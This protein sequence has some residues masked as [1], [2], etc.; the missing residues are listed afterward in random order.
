MSYI[1]K[2]SSPVGPVESWPIVE[3]D[4]EKWYVAPVYVAP[5]ARRDIS[6]VCD[7]WGCEVPTAKLVDA[8][9]EQSDLKLDCTK[10]RRNYNSFNDM[11]TNTAYELQSEKIL[12]QISEQLKE[13]G[14]D[15]YSI[16]SGT[17]KDFAILPNG[18][19]DLYGWHHL[20]GTLT[21]KGATSHSQ[22]YIDYSQG[23]RLVR[24][25]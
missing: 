24:K 18:R 4:G 21:E 16:V 5:I 15:S 8:I 6:S 14:T 23:L 20:D 11:A 25:V 17:Q 12:K 19:T 2:I 7:E 1:G 3:L 9:W 13:N 22:T 10:L